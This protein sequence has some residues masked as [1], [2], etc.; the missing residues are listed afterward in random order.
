MGLGNLACTRS[1]RILGTEVEG[2][3]I[4]MPAAAAASDPE[5][6]RL[7]LGQTSVPQMACPGKWKHELNPVFLFF[8]CGGLILTHTHFTT[9]VGLSIGLN[10]SKP[11]LMMISCEGGV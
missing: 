10:M 1:K 5:G 11:L 8:F 9:R 4:A 7:A 2:S 3:A 6:C